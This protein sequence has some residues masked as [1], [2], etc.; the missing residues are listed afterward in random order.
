M[1]RNEDKAFRE[2]IE[3]SVKSYKDSQKKK[4]FFRYLSRVAIAG[5]LFVIPV[6]AGAYLGR[7]LDGK[8]AGGISWTITLIII[9]VAAGAYNV[10][11]FIGGR[12]A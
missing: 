8:F 1:N 3:G 11:Y 4:G 10:W 5:W 7:Y 2:S 12:G 6:I 9:G